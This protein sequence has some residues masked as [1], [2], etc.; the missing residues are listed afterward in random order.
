MINF[1]FA[2]H[3]RLAEGVK[4]AAEIILGVTNNLSVISAYINNDS[5]LPK[6]VEDIIDK[7]KKGGTWVVV[8]DIFGGSVNNEFMQY[9]N[10]A[11]FMLIS[12]LNL[13][14]ALELLCMSDK[15]VNTDYIRKI[16]SNVKENIQLCNDLLEENKEDEHF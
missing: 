7:M 16:V 11:E 3:G 5:D 1:V 12:G 2:S 8:T 14:M 15:D 6:D 10:D 4:N 13:G 9:L